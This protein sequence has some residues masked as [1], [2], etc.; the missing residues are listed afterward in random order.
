MVAQRL[1]Q[2]RQGLVPE[3]KA[4][5]KTLPDLGTHRYSM[6]SIKFKDDGQFL[7]F[8]WNCD[9]NLENPHQPLGA[10]DS[11]PKPI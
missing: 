10:C 11:N 9:Q 5:P 1:M 8:F 6:V 4:T 3:N 2:L 7:Y